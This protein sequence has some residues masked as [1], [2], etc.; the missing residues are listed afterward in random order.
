MAVEPR[1]PSRTALLTAAAR[2]LHRAGPPPH[3]LDDVLAQPLAGADGRALM[4]RLRAELSPES[5]LSFSRWVAV[6]ARVPEDLVEQALA[7]GTRQYV[8]LGA[9]LDTFA[10]RRRD[11]L[12]RL[13]V[14]EVDHPASQTW[15]RRRLAELGLDLPA[16]LVFAPVDFERQ[17]LREGLEDAGFDFAAPAVFSWI[18]VTLYLTIEAIGATLGIIAACAPGSRIVLTYNQPRSVL[19]GLGLATETTLAA[20][21]AALGEPMISLFTPDEI[22]RLLRDHGFADIVHFGPAEAI[23]AYFPGR[24]DVRFGGAQRLVVA[25]LPSGPGAG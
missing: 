25:T 23:A 20:I 1:P 3:I 21:V 10:Y 7:A 9:G 17:T 22:E 24:N 13:R 14:I 4:A 5:W 12:A 18:G 19:Q 16:N 2:T 11:L 15:K 8:I 6:R